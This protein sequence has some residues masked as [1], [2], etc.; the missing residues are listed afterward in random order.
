MWHQLTCGWGGGNA[1]MTPSTLLKQSYPLLLAWKNTLCD[2]ESNT[3]PSCSCYETTDFCSSN[4]LSPHPYSITT[5][6]LL[7][8]HLGACASPHHL[9]KPKPE[10]A[11]HGHSHEQIAR[12]WLKQLRKPKQALCNFTRSLS[13]MMQ[14]TGKVFHG[15][16]NYANPHP[17]LPCHEIPTLK[18]LWISNLSVTYQPNDYPSLFSSLWSSTLANTIP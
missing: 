2:T 1:L 12:R 5:Q 16:K 11:W 17:P 8:N 18:L 10:T 6:A 15:P 14:E 4:I 7:L 13:R 9:R 3:L